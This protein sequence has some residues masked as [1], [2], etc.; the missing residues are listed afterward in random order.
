MDPVSALSVAAAVVQFIEVGGK[1]V[2]TY[3]EVRSR[4]KGQPAE[5][6]SLAASAKDVSSLSSTAKERVDSLGSSYP[7]HAE[8]LLRVT[9]EIASVE[10]K[11]QAGMERLTV[12]PKKH[13]TA[14][15]SS[16]VVA[17]RIVWSHRELEQW[18]KQLSGLRDQVIM[19]VLMCVWD[20]TKKSDT[21]AEHILQAVQR[22]EKA[23]E[24]HKEVQE[25]GPSQS[26]NRI[27]VYQAIWASTA[28]SDTSTKHGYLPGV[29]QKMLMLDQ[30]V[31]DTHESVQR[32]NLSSLAYDD[33]DDRV[34]GIKSAF[35][36]TFEWIFDE[37]R[38]SFRKWLT[39]QANTVFWITGV[40]ASGK[41]TLMKFVTGHDSLRSLLERWAPSGKFYIARFYFWNPGSRTQKSRVG[42][43]RSLLFQLLHDRPDLVSEAASRRLLYFSIAGNEAESPEWEW[44]ELCESLVN[45]ACRLR[46]EEVK[47]VLFIDGLDEYEGY[48]ENNVD[49]LRKTDEMVQFLMDLQRN[50]G[51]RLCVSSRPLNYFRDKFKDCP[52]LAMQQLTQPDID[53]YIDVRLES[54]QAVQDMK[55][56]DPE[57]VERLIRDLKSK[58]QGVFLWVILVVEELLLS[59]LDTPH[60]PAVRAVFDSLPSGI[61]K[62]YDAIQEKATPEKQEAASKLYQ[63]LFEYKRLCSGQMSATFLWLA[64]VYDI[65][66]PRY[67]MPET[68][69]NIARL[70][71]RLVEGQ[72]R[73]IL[74]VLYPPFPGVPPKV[75]FL[76]KT[77]YEWTHRPDIWHRIIR[78]G[79][80]RYQ[81]ILAILAVVVSHMESI[82]NADI[83]LEFELRQI[84]WLA[85]HVPDTA[86]CRTRLVPVIDK[87][88]TMNLRINTF[89]RKY[90]RLANWK[91]DEPPL[92]WA[93]VWGCHTYIQG[94][95]DLSNTT[96]LSP[97]KKHRMSF[98]RRNPPS[99]KISLLEAAIFGV[100]DD[101]RH[102]RR[103]AWNEFNRLKTVEVLMKHGAKMDKRLIKRLKRQDN[104]YT[105]LLLSLDNDRDMLADFD[106]T[107]AREYPEE[108]ILDSVDLFV[109]DGLV[110]RKRMEV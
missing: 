74:Q 53:R 99:D 107:L 61:T 105:R 80:S 20:E 69:P 27:K 21:K 52:S 11:I 28:L 96:A 89:I 10:S 104:R 76:Y 78:A 58:A 41:S 56:A 44:E 31:P 65:E 17:I 71:Q 90:F 55:A 100:E 40:P 18:E 15:G 37:E 6:V 32:R 63:L 8:S 25:C 9:A 42:L 1:L 50:Y 79:P 108:E 103:S 110:F 19:N 94:K 7:R 30:T 38:H 47:I 62:L 67:P 34:R 3:F 64:A 81:P 93:A 39:S 45:L 91:D 101:D 102:R 51:V 5:V 49:S 13:S 29:V 83:S 24:A 77:A 35:P 2:N 66:Q 97:G 72:T 82:D 57:E 88:D 60:M 70:T 73:G 36:E 84:F 12:N 48:A 59:C 26:G 95:L 16:M 4:G 14:A 22:I 75:E 85:S 43:L 106:A 98:L 23:L 46:A 86:E 109:H 92:S 87:L 33:M 54:S 68:Q